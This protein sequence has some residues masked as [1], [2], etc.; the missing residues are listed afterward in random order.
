MKKILDLLSEDKL[1]ETIKMDQDNIVL[2]VFNMY[3]I[4]C[5]ETCFFNFYVT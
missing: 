5:I 2:K 1:S 4:G 3:D